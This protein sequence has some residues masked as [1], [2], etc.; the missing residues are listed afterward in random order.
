[1]RGHSSD[2]FSTTVL[3]YASGV[4]TARVAED[5]RRVPGRDRHDHARG[6]RGRPSRACRARPRGSPRRRARRPGRRPRAASPAASSTVE[7]APAERAAGLLGDDRGDLGR[8]LLE[9]VGGLRADLARA[10]RAACA[11]TAGNA[12]AAASTAARA[13]S[14]RPPRRCRRGSPVNGFGLLVRRRRSSRR[15]TPADQQLL[16]LESTGGHVVSPRGEC[17]PWA[18]QRPW[19]D[20]SAGS[21]TCTDRLP[22]AQ[23]CGRVPPVPPVD[24]DLPLRQAAVARARQLTQAYDDLVPVEILRQGF[25]FEGERIS[26][27]SFQKG[28]HRARVQRGPAALTLTTSVKDPYVDVYDD[29]GFTYAYRTGPIDQADNRDYAPRTRY[30]HR[31]SISAASRPG[32]YWVVAPTFVIADDP[33]TRTVRLVPGLPLQDMQP[34]GRFRRRRCAPTRCRYEDSQVVGVRN[35]L[36]IRSIFQCSLF[37]SN[38]CKFWITFQLIKYFILHRHLKSTRV[39]N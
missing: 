39:M 3:P 19:V 33:G 37:C 13:S 10:R 14:R 23:R 5:H 6:L 1:M 9:Q 15:A 11:T 38:S 30:R 34:G 29:A 32:Q 24:P 4:A 25:M 28:I 26:F 22:S 8:A 17:S 31:S 21:P 12:A 2:A 7:H 16:L 36:H 20:G 35:S 27:G 18:P